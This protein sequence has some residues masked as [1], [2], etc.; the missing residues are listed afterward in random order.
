M[1]AAAAAA[2]AVSSSR[3][4]LLLQSTSNATFV[5][6]PRRTL[7]ATTLALSAP[8]QLSLVPAANPKYHNAKVDAGDE[9]VEGEE[10][11]RRFNWQVSRAGVM[12]EIRR[13]RRHEDARDKRKRKARSAARRFRRR[14]F[15]GPYPFSDDQGAKEQAT[16]DEENDNWELPAGELP[17]YR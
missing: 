5:S 2:V 9:D 8:S 14:R 11:L 15:K 4:P 10:L 1:A 13:R 3:P 7:P 17:S 12:E 6:F 16:D